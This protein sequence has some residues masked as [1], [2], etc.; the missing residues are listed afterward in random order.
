MKTLNRKHFKNKKIVAFLIFCLVIIINVSAQEGAYWQGISVKNPAVIGTP[1]DWVFGDYLFT[2]EN[3]LTPGDEK[4]PTALA[5]GVDYRIA[6]EIGSFGII[7][8]KEKN[9]IEDVVLM[10]MSYAYS[11]PLNKGTLNFGV[12]GGLWKYKNDFSRYADDIDPLFN[13]NFQQKHLKAGVGMFYNS[14]KL[15]L[16][17]SMNRFFELDK[18]EESDPYSYSSINYTSNLVTVLG[19]YRFN[20]FDKLVIEPNLMVD[21]K[22]GNTDVFPGV[23]F[24]FDEMFWAGY[25]NLDLNNQHSII[26]GVD[27]LKRFR[28]GYSYSFTKIFSSKNGNI[29][30]FL[31]GIRLDSI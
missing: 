1:S 6:P 16:G 13:P 3:K 27:I 30:E 21:F 28:A 12:S 10:E 20:C 29:H 5:I 11:L 7:Y 2:N 14:D 8:T 4:G 23:Y 31:L 9:A 15:D 22:D 26:L 25:T 24:E 19:A 17:I 18:N